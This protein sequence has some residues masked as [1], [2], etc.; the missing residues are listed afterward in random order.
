MALNL[1]VSEGSGVY[2]D[3]EPL[4]VIT[5]TAPEEDRGWLA[6][7]EKPDGSRYELSEDR[8]VEVFPGVHMHLGLKNQIGRAGQAWC[9]KHIP[10]GGDFNGKKLPCFSSLVQQLQD[11]GTQ[12]CGGLPLAQIRT[13]SIRATARRS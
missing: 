4:R 8:K 11:K 13:C 9:L 10:D 6:T 3:S 5:V 1:S 2:I 12:T 7:V